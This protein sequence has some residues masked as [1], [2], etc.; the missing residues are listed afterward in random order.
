MSKQD[1]HPRS[2][3]GYI[4]PIGGAEEKV[5]DRHILRRFLEICGGKTADIAIIPTAS[6]LPDTGAQ[7]VEVFRDM[8][9]RSAQSLDTAIAAYVAEMPL[10]GGIARDLVLAKVKSYLAQEGS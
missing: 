2:T 4:V 3:R 8:G 10:E 6:Q 5:R 1:D 7:Y 9:V